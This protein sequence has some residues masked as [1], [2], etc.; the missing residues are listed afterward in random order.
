MS[1]CQIPIKQ[2]CPY[3]WRMSNLEQKRISIEAD[4]YLNPFSSDASAKEEGSFRSDDTKKSLE[5]RLTEWLLRSTWW[6][7]CLTMNKLNSLVMQLIPQ[8][9]PILAASTLKCRY[10]WTSGD[11]TLQ[12]LFH[13]HARACALTRLFFRISSIS[14]V[15]TFLG[16]FSADLNSLASKMAYSNSLE[17]LW[18]KEFQ[19][20]E[21][22]EEAIQPS[23]YSFETAKVSY[24]VKSL[25]LSMPQRGY[26]RSHR[27]KFPLSKRR[28]I[29]N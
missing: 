12:Y 22:S 8:M 27:A 14:H 16:Q 17:S 7:S 18:E 9:I 25:I 4:H 19:L 24:Y 20:S 21:I 3:P 15:L 13:S 1:G 6:C 28:L 10:L 2:G 26:F 5:D 29:K 11:W 23:Q